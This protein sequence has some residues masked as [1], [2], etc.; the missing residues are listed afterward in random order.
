[1]TKVGTNQDQEKEMPRRSYGCKTKPTIL[2]TRAQEPTSSATTA[3]NNNNEFS[4]L[5]IMRQIMSHYYENNELLMTK[6]KSNNELMESIDELY[7]II[8]KNAHF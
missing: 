1:V 6:C 4:E 7:V 8:W 3:Q 5:I 2:K